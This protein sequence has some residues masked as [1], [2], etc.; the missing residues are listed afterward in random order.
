MTTFIVVSYVGLWLLVIMLLLVV[1]AVVR[2]I[3]LLHQR[4]ARAGARMTGDG[5]PIG[6]LAPPIDVMDMR[7]VAVTLGAIRGKLTM[8]VL[9]SPTC[10]VCSALLPA[11]KSIAKSERRY[12]EVVLLA[13]GGDEQ[14]HRDYQRLHKIGDLP[15]VVSDDV[16]ER[17]EMKTAPIAVLVGS[18]GLIKARGVVNH[19][20]HLDSL[21]TA[22]RLGHPTLESYM[23]MRGTQGRTSEIVGASE[24]Q[25]SI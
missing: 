19:L 18:D 11:V 9:V 14:M 22:A 20:E 23:G 17:Y 6:Q 12:L 21:L 8:L 7:G 1:F 3:G 10:S 2:Q 25:M 5:L 16:A 13:T 15:Y 4:I 24:A